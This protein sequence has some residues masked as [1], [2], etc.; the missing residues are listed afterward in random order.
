[1]R[2]ASI[3][4]ANNQSINQ[5]IKRAKPSQAA[6]A[7]ASRLPILTFVLFLDTRDCLAARQYV[8]IFESR[9]PLKRSDYFK[10]QGEALNTFAPKSVAYFSAARNT[11]APKSVAYF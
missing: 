1:M 4:P 7:T 10:T 2:V 3:K 11:L 9:Y 8:S 5:S 6:P